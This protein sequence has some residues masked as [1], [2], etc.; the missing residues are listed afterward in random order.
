MV[1]QWRWL[2]ESGQW[3]ENVD[4]TQLVLASSKPVLQKDL[5]RASIRQINNSIVVNMLKTKI[6]RICPVWAF[7]LLSLA[8]IQFN[9]WENKRRWENLFL[10]SSRT[11]KASKNNSTKHAANYLDRQWRWKCLF[12]SPWRLRF[13]VNLLHVF[14]QAGVQWA[15]DGTRL[16][17]TSKDLVTFSSPLLQAVWNFQNIRLKVCQRI[18]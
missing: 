16:M 17:P 11:Q 12:V 14:I 2:E 3:L 5:L 6:H 8:D 18:N 15:F 4:P 9:S 13:S 7:C 1:N 10:R